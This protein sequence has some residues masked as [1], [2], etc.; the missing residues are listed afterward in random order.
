LIEGKKGIFM[1]TCVPIRVFSYSVRNFPAIRTAVT[2]VELLVVMAVIGVLVGL[3]LPAVQSARESARRLQCANHLKQIA[4]AVASYEIAMKTLPP[5]NFAATWGVCPGTH[6]PVDSADSEDRANWLILLLP[7]LEKNVLAKNYHEGAANEDIQNRPLRETAVAEYVCP[8]DPENSRL[9]IPAM[10]PGAE[11]ALNV[12]Y[13]PGSYRA[14]AGRSDGAVFLDGGYFTSFPRR[15]RGPIHVVGIANYTPERYKDIRD[16]ASQTLMAGES[17]TRS[18]PGFRTL[19]AYSYAFYSLS[20]ATPQARVLWGDYD[21]CQA[22]EGEGWSFPCRRGWGGGH[23][24]GINFTLCDGSVHF[25]VDEIDPEL[26]AELA[27]ID[28]RESA[29]LPVP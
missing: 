28:G 12:P 15:Y 29:A 25:V 23:R 21:R 10:G 19:W 7:Y 27:T 6:P 2:L 11:D 20:S 18:N 14:M 26:F 17:V 8:S 4:S 5:G 24:G 16:G 22:E 1:A 3:L 9:Q 13:Q